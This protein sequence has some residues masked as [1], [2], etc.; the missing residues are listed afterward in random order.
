MNAF[1]PLPG[2]SGPADRIA[3]A[4]QLTARFAARA[5][6]SDRLGR[7]SFENIA[8]L[9]D[10]GLLALGIPQAHGGSGARL[11][12]TLEIVRA[13]GAGDPSTALVLLMQILHHRAIATRGTW[14][15]HV[16]EQVYR[17]AVAD[18]A[19]INAL[20]VEPD[21]GSPVRGGIP[22][23]R[24]TRTAAGWRLCGRKLYSTGA[25]A[26][27][28]GIVWA[29]TDEASPRIGEFLVP[30][31]TPGVRIET[32]WD[33]LGLRA[34]GSEDVIL[35]QV[36]IPLDHA[37]DLRE[38]QDWGR[39]DVGL[40]AW[41]P[42]MLAA[43]YDGV[44]RAARD[45]LFDFLRTRTPA[46]L[47]R[48]LA[49]VPRIA[50]AAGEIEALLQVNDALLSAIPA[51]IEA[52]GVP[53]PDLVK[54][55]VTRNAIAAVEQALAVVGN[56]GLKRANPLERHHRDALCARVHHPQDDLILEGA[57]RAALGA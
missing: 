49:T 16:R 34:S 8:D 36:E 15:A 38:P 50:A 26:L 48:P 39:S 17:G 41:L 57:G 47:G 33:H 56:H 5:G 53:R 4:R 31:D 52:G 11:P 40:N 13:I 28:W 32:T 35:D 7:F 44:A 3:R 2:T 14:P 10:A 20:R 30:L 25:P 27:R 6:D 24:A 9:R 22:A 55:T 18:G 37:V 51:R 23:T 29:A 21:L 46:N 43:L 12:E 45:W 1:T 54:L 42:L 19:L